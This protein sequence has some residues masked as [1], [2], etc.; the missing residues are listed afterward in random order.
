METTTTN[1]VF[2]EYPD[3]LATIIQEGTPISIATD[4][5]KSILKSGGEWIITSLV[6]NML[7]HGANPDLGNMENMYSYRS[8]VYA[9]LS[10]F[11]FISEYSKYFSL[12]FNNQC[13]LYC[14]NKKIVKK[15]QKISTTTNKFQPYYKMSE[16][17]TIIAI[18]YYLLRRI[19]VIH[20]YSH[21]DKVKGKKTYFPRKTKQFSR[22]HRR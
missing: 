6:G 18:K 3:S 20:L 22:L 17:E 7:V 1:H 19:N 13:T 5:T 11:L 15:I 16:H 14:D 21:Q 12:Q 4:G 2:T 10:V 8:E 9:V